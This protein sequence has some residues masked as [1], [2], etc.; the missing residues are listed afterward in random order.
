MLR[1]LLNAAGSWTAT[2]KLRDP[3]NRISGDSKS[4]ATVTPLLDGRF[5]RIDYDWEDKGKPQ[6]G[7]MLIGWEKSTGVATI[8]WIDTW[9][10]SDRIMISTGDV[11]K[12]GAIDVRGTY[13]TAPAEPDWG[14]HTLLSVDEDILSMVMFNVDPQGHEELAVDAQYTRTI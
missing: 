5:V 9:H 14:W 3:E 13:V 4:T 6:S 7:S 12:D 1:L 8:A 2:Y 11:N 10:N